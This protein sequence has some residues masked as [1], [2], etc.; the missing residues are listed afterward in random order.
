M[1][2]IRGGLVVIAGV[3]LFI[4]ILVG[5]LFLTLSSSLEY[6]NVVPEFTSAVKETFTGEFNL[7]SG[8]IK[9]SEAMNLYCKNY[10]SYVFSQGE[11][12]FEIPCE[13]ILQGPDKIL[14][15][16]MKQLVK[17]IYYTDYDCEFLLGCSKK[18]QQPLFLVSEQAKNYWNDKFY[19]ALGI[20]ALLIAIMFIFAEH[21]LDLF[22]KIG[23]I[24]IIS[25]LPFMKL[26]SV[27]SFFNFQF[28]QFLS[29]F[30]S[31]SYDVFL[32]VLILGIIFAATGL[33]IKLFKFGFKLNSIFQKKE[34]VSE[35]TK[36][37]E[38]QSSQKERVEKKI[39]SANKKLK[40]KSK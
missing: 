8:I 17:K 37:E 40:D 32:K 3:L 35:E 25:S 7:E 20:S 22:T 13:I 16:G 12:T 26:D 34:A 27:V 29:I 5:N 11:Y 19:L 10:R 24:L 31:K 15:E 30:V 9:Q 39:S 2:L 33:I 1:G 6:E 38:G 36:K 18:Y 14:D 23:G 21:R 28:V 4:S